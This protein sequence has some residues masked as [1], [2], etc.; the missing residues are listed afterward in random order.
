MV[1]EAHGNIYTSLHL[2][3]WVFFFSKCVKFVLFS[4]LEDYKWTDVVALTMRF[5]YYKFAHVG[6]E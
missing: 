1:T 2:L 3:M 5:P 4:I 6:L